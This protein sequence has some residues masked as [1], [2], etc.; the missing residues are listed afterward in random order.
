[1]RFAVGLT[2]A[3]LFAS[4][5]ARARL[6]PELSADYTRNNDLVAAG[7]EARSIGAFFLQS[8]D[9]VGVRFYVGIRR[10]D[11]DSPL[12]NLASITVVPVGFL[13]SF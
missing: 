10:Y 6:Q 4:G 2:L 3:L 1:M 11:V 9:D 8:W 13:I 7:D 12:V 5:S